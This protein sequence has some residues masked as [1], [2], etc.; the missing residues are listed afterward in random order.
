VGAQP[1]GGL[2]ESGKVAEL[3]V[4]QEGEPAVDLPIV[5]VVRP[6]E[7]R[8]P[9]RLPVDSSEQRRAAYQLEGERGALRRI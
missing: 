2:V 6:A 1:A 9:A 7:S 4:A 3:V 8:E 5:E